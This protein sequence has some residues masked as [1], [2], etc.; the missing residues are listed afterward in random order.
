MRGLIIIAAVLLAA[1]PAQAG[2]YR[3][4]HGKLHI[5][6]DTWAAALFSAMV[7]EKPWLI[8]ITTFGEGNGAGIANPWTDSPAY[9]PQ[10]AP[11]SASP[12][13]AQPVPTLDLVSMDTKT[14]ESNSTWT[15]VSW[16]ATV[17]N[18]ADITQRGWL[19]VQV[20]DSSG[21]VLDSHPGGRVVLDAGESQEYSDYILIDADIID[22]V[23]SIAV[24][25][26]G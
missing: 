17:R 18:P 21:F 4:D 25:L 8:N 20:L 24:A 15:K 14:V 12:E 19:E 1:V 5:Y 13:P 9:Q 11:A 2:S 6:V 3:D 22:Q 7:A 10:A 23:Q 26:E 16:R